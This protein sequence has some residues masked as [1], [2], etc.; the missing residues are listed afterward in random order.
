MQLEV[1]KEKKEEKAYPSIRAALIS[2]G[3]GNYFGDVGI[4]CGCGGE[5]SEF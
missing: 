2:I 3:V 5:S 1:H 4:N